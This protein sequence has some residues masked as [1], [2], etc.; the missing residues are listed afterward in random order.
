MITRL[1][2]LALVAAA[3]ITAPASRAQTLVQAGRGTVS[4]AVQVGLTIPPRLRFR[5]AN[6]TRVGQQGDTTTYAMDVEVAANLAWTL[7]AVP[8]A[9][10]DAPQ[11][12][13]VKDADGAWRTLRAGEPMVTL[14]AAQ[15][16]SNWRA[17]RIEVQVISAGGPRALPSLSLDL[18][19][20][21]R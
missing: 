2:L 14:I 11:S 13:R 6:Q 21:Q 10:D 18:Q 19:P 4:T 8:A 9:S 1:R 15:Q 12:L 7:G 20:A 5:V 17:V 3:T 16:P